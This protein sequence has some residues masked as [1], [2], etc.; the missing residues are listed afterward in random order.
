MKKRILATL[1]IGLIL[2]SVA[3][4]SSTPGSS[5]ST[6]TPTPGSGGN[7]T[8]SPS[9]TVSN[10]SDVPETGLIGTL[11]IWCFNT[12]GQIFGLHSKRKIPI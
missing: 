4:C 2:V 10:A 1:L 5:P 3:G 11:N 8:A 7:P 12:D 6:G 9:P